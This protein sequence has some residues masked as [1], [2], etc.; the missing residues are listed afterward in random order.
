MIGNFIIGEEVICKR[1]Y[2]YNG[3]FDKN[4]KFIVVNF[5]EYNVRLKTKFGTFH[6][7]TYNGDTIDLYYF[8]LF[9]MKQELRKLKLKEIF[10]DEI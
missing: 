7:I 4:D 10:H 1:H 9:Y 2:Y 5:N 3:R 8:D 6:N